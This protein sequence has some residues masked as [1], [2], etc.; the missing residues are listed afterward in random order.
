MPLYAVEEMIGYSE[1][2]VTVQKTKP[3]ALMAGFL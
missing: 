1:S 3:T 2:M